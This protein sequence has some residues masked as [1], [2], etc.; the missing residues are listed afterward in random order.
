ML[1]LE[2]LFIVRIAGYGITEPTDVISGWSR[3]ASKNERYAADE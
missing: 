3:K 2:F 1:G